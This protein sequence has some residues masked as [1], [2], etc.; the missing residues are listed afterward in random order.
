MAKGNHHKKLK[1]DSPKV[2]VQRCYFETY[3]IIVLDRSV[4]GNDFLRS[5]I[6]LIVIRCLILFNN[7][8]RTLLQ[9]HKMV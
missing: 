5:I 8:Y 9:Q 2:A 6:V 7:L 4:T 1:N 3:S